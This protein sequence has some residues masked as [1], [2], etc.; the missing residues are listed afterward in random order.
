MTYNNMGQA[1]QEENALDDALAWYQRALQLDPNSGRIHCNLASLLAEQEKYE[2]AVARYDAALRLDPAYAEAHCGLGAV[3]HE[4]GNYAQAEAHQREALRLQPDLAAAHSALGMVREE[5][6]DF[7][8]AERCWRTALR[9]D[10]RQAGAYAQLATLLRGKLPDE[11]LAGLRRLLADPDLN[12]ARRSALHFGLAQA[13]DARGAY[14]EA[15]ESL[16]QAN[17]LALAGA[18]RRGQG[19]DPAEHA[20]FVARLIATCTPAFFE[21]VRGLGLDS[22]R[23][24]FIL[25]LPRSGTTLTEQVLASHSRVFGAGELR[26]ARDNFE[27]LAGAVGDD[28]ALE[29]LGRLDGETIRRVGERHLEQLRELNADRAHVADKMPDNYLYLGLLAALFPKAKFIH[30]RRDLR[31]IA[32][33]CWMTN[34]RHIRWANDPDDIAARFEEYRRVME[35]WRRALPVP[36]LDVDYEE[37]VADLEGVARRL[38]AWCGLE[39]EPAC[40]AFHE[41][42]RPV[43]TASVSQVRQPVYKRSVARWKNYEKALGCLFRRLPPA[44]A[45]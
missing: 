8:E 17:A 43:R 31:D 42:K 5:L 20:R 28:R 6:G 9:H 19:Y 25:G 22:A 26:L 18:K 16:R 4:Q 29:A 30:C 12:D 37:T 41:G 24:I 27:A 36:L 21:R 38:L 23:P 39:W 34:F 35:H 13:L 15:A 33:S 45:P 7:A 11:D 40:L 10:P 44:P 14:A 32:V 1:L 2:E 3:R